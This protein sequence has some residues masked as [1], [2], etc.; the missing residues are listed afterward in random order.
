MKMTIA[1]YDRQIR[2]VR[3]HSRDDGKN[4]IVINQTHWYDADQ[5]AVSE[6]IDDYNRKHHTG[7]YAE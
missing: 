2:K 4:Y 7:P 3:W 5:Y 6:A 1:A